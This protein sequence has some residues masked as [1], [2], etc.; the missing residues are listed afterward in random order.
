MSSI[1]SI[2]ESFPHPTIPP[3]I[4]LPTY[5]AIANFLRLLN[6]NAASVH[7]ESGGGLLG[8]LTLTVSPAVYTT[9]SAVPFV[10]PNNPGA[11]PV[12]P[13]GA[14]TAQIQALLRNH[15]ETL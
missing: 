4:G 2:I 1:N 3:I 5:E 13:A 10:R 14:T 8:H 15:K 9:L 6:A 12:V 11:V 7:S